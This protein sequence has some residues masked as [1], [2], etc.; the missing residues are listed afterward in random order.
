MLYRNR[1]HEA[2]LQEA[3]NS[4]KKYEAWYRELEQPFL[5]QKEELHK[6]KL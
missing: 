5:V 6:L 2:L 3:E 1:N 4:A